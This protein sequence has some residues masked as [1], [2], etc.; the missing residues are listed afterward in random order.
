MT[1]FTF[2][3]PNPIQLIAI[4]IDGTL[5]DSSGTLPARNRKAIK[6]AVDAGIEIVLVTGRAFHHARPV[7]DALAEN[8][9]LIVNNGKRKAVKKIDD[10]PFPDWE[11]FDIQ[12]YLADTKKHPPKTFGGVSHVWFYKPEDAV[13][14]PVNTARGCVFK[15]T[16]CHYVY[17]HD[18]YRQRS[19]Q[20]VLAEIKQNQKKYGA[21]FFNFWDELTFHK[22][23]PAEKFVDELIKADLKVHWTCSIRADLMGRDVDN[24]GKPIP[25]E[26]RLNLAKKFVQAGCTTVNFSLESGSDEILEAMNRIRTF[27]CNHS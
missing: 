15:C 8:I 7:V 18:P 10:F 4:D 9:N 23:G 2:V 17:W 27:I 19:A 20:N 6:R 21:N 12:T 3:P 24:K 25:R 11:L 5:L 14:M 16:F 22:I 26:T 13:A 1:P